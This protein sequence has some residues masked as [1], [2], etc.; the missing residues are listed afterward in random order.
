MK[1]KRWAPALLIMGV[2]IFFSSQ[3][4]NELP[5]FGTL[6]YFVKKG[7]HVLGYA[8]LA[9]SFYYAMERPSN[10]MAWFLTILFALSDEYHQ[11][12]VAGRTSSFFDV[13]VFDN[14]GALVGLWFWEKWRSR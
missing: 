10:K 12:F 8:L 9:A 5:D 4:S 11:S 6:D 2:I 1:L 13:I 3:P 7:G 14:F